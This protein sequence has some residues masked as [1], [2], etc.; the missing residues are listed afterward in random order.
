ML[1]YLS[2]SGE[3]VT[4]KVIEKSRFITTSKHVENEEEAKAFVERVAA[5]YGDATHNC[6]AYICDSLGNFLRFS[7]DGEPQGTA[8]M[9]ILEAVKNKKLVQTAVVVTRYFG[10]IKLGAG[11]LVRAYSGC[12]AEN[13]DAA[14]KVLY[15]ECAESLYIV[16]YSGVDTALRYFSECGADVINAEYLNEVIF[17]VA[18]KKS[19]E[20]KFNS[21]L[22]NRLNGRVKIKKEKEYFFPFKI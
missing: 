12:V 10:G 9:P 15:E 2:I 7:D 3:C 1:K 6:Y 5:K 13:L 18:V 16:D 17:T 4:Q 14:N 20:Q 11:G 21:E 8:G 19:E 22:I